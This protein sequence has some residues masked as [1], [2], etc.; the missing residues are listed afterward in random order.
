M[1]K[2]LELVTDKPV[3]I[4]GPDHIG[5][6]V[7][8]GLELLVKT[9]VV[10]SAYCEMSKYINTLEEEEQLRIEFPAIRAIYEEYQLLIKMYKD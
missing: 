4:I 2:S 3:R 7:E 10:A 8:P 1:G 9:K 5:L 6:T